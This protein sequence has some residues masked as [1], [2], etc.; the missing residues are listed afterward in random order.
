MAFQI[1]NTISLKRFS[2][3]LMLNICRYTVCLWE[4]KTHLHK[5]MNQVILC[6]A[7]TFKAS[8]M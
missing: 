8:V 6:F 2:T 4:A 1:T 7:I 5:S 3:A